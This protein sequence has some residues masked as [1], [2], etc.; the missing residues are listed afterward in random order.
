LPTSFG[1]LCLP[2][3]FGLLIDK[4]TGKPFFYLLKHKNGAKLVKKDN[5]L[6]AE[7]QQKDLFAIRLGVLKFE[8]WTNTDKTGK[9]LCFSK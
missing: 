1:L 6:I 3:S 5:K 4:K 7:L 2:T 9:F 8:G